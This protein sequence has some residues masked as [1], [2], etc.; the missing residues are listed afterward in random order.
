MNNDEASKLKD[1]IANFKSSSENIDSISKIISVI[2]NQSQRGN[3]AIHLM[4]ADT[5]FA[6]SL[7]QSLLNIESGTV[8]LN[9]DLEALKSNFLLRGY[10]KKKEKLN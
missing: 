7:K 10:F 6:S 8:K 3:N 1:M 2:I 9:E 4:T 5:V